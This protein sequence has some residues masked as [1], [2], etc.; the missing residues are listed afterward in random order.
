MCTQFIKWLAME[1]SYGSNFLA[2]VVI[3]NKTL[4]DWCLIERMS[5]D[6]LQQKFHKTIFEAQKRH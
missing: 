3:G 5:G 1:I 2:L 6:L 4:W